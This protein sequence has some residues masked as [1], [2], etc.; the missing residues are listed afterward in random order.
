MM[1]SGC[2]LYYIFLT[3]QTCMHVVELE[4]S[5][6]L[7]CYRSVK[8]KKWEFP[9]RIICTSKPIRALALGSSRVGAGSDFGTCLF[10]SINEINPLGDGSTKSDPQLYMGQTEVTVTGQGHL[11]S[12]EHDETQSSSRSG[13]RSVPN[14]SQGSSGVQAKTSWFRFHK[15]EGLVLVTGHPNG[16]IRCWN[17]HN[18]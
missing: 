12:S 11:T 5:V 8:T 13:S 7:L 16:H 10:Q 14:V 2:S 6:L 17:A 9:E 4:V 1:G 18:G 3:C 15:V